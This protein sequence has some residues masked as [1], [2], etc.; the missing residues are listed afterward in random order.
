MP[1]RNFL[2]LRVIDNSLDVVH[3]KFDTYTLH[4]TVICLW[5]FFFYSVVQKGSLFDFKQV[6]T[7]T[8]SIGCLS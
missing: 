4:G 6:N 5:D 3:T 2:D 8:Q 7:T 1:N